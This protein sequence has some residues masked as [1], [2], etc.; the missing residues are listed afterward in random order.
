MICAM[1]PLSNLV[2]SPFSLFRYF[3]FVRP[4]GLRPAVCLVIEIYGYFTL[5]FDLVGLIASL[6]A[7]LI[8]ITWSC[9][10]H[11]IASFLFN[12]VFFV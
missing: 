8:I 10:I 7:C 11:C 1:Q 2:L 3:C 12:F 5:P 9:V 6:Q 4:Y